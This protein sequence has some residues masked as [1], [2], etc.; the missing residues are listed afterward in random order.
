MI[1]FE[2]TK[3]ADLI[4]IDLHD[5]LMID[6][7]LWHHQSLTFEREF[8]AVYIKFPMLLKARDLDSIRVFYQGHPV[9]AIN[10]PWEGGLVW[11]ETPD[12]NPFAGVTCQGM[13]ASTWWPCKDHLS[14]EPD[15]MRLS[16]SVPKG[17]QCI[18][19][20]QLTGQITQGDFTTFNWK[21]TYPINTYNVTF[22]IS[23]YEHLEDVYVNQQGDSLQLDYYVLPSNRRK[24]KR[25]FDQ[26][27]PML[28]CFDHYFGA[29]PFWNDGYKLV[30]APY[31][32]MEHQSAIAYG[33]NYKNNTFGFDFI[34]VHESGHEWW[35]NSIS[36]SD[37]AEMW[38][39]EAFTTYSESL[40]IEYYKGEKEARKYLVEQRAHIND[41]YPLLG[42]YG[43]F[44]RDWRDTDIYYKGAWMLH[45]IR[46]TINNDSL[47]FSILKGLYQEYQLQIVTS[48]QITGYINQ[49]TE[50]GLEPMF[51]QYLTK[52][53][54]PRLQYSL[55]KTDQGVKMIYH[56]LS[57]VE[58][59]EMPVLI[60]V[61]GK[62]IRL[63]PNR[64]YQEIMLSDVP[65]FL[66]SY[67][68]YDLEELP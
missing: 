13:G 45:S 53:Y 36:S 7:I 10:P 67:F 16:L 56:W 23:E 25:H 40:W 60:E 6:S 34:I 48:D 9:Q 55:N 30:E 5:T 18:S 35:G 44:S 61:E 58:G 50:I 54:P 31:W 21:V 39:N 52:T 57:N 49:H 42:D 32:G 43:V 28:D 29:Y 24:A 47:W 37:L 64:D 20:G 3:D 38:I 46:H 1:F 66:T 17:L 33:N 65:E 22:Y 14:D 62:Q 26:V 8:S 12:G 4:Q 63:F 2:M 19:N 68:Y 11:A 41:W 27:K 15:S 59:F 51:E